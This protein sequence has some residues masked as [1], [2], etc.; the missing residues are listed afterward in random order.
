MRT[1]RRPIVTSR[2]IE[3]NAAHPARQKRRKRNA[4]GC[5]FCCLYNVQLVFGCCKTGFYTILAFPYAS[6]KIQHFLG[7]CIFFHTTF[8]KRPLIGFHTL[9]P[10]SSSG[11]MLFSIASAVHSWHSSAYLSTQY[12]KEL[13]LWTVS[14]WLTA[15]HI[16]FAPSLSVTYY[17]ALIY[18]TFCKFTFLPSIGSKNI[19]YLCNRKR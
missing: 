19:A 13:S 17:T 5:F 9:A 15:A 4:H 6:A 11:S 12:V 14:F 7:L 16:M 18:C 10:P 8:T 2:C 1:A 3:R